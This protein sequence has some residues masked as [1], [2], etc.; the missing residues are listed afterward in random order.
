MDARRRRQLEWYLRSALAIA[1][2]SN[3]SIYTHGPDNIG[4][5]GL[6]TPTLTWIT[7]SSVSKPQ[8]AITFAPTSAA[9]VSDILAIT[10]NGVEYNKTLTA[11]HIAEGDY[12]VAIPELLNAT[13]TVWLKWTRGANYVYSNTISITI[14]DPY[15]VPA[16]TAG[17]TISGTTAPTGDLTA[18]WT[19]T[20]RP[21]PTIAHQWKRGGSNVGTNSATYTKSGADVGFAM[22]DDITASSLAGSTTLSSNAINVVAAGTFTKTYGNRQAIGAVTSVTWASADFGT[23]SGSTDVIIAVAYGFNSISGTP[24]LTVDG[25]S[26]TVVLHNDT[27]VTKTIFYRINLTSGGTKTVVISTA[28][29]FFQ[30]NAY[31][32]IGKLGA[33]LN[34]VASATYSNGYSANGD[35]H[36]FFSGQ[37]VPASGVGVFVYFIFNTNAISWSG[38]T[39]IFD[40]FNDGTTQV[41]W[42]WTDSDTDPTAT[43]GGNSGDTRTMVAWGP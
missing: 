20:G 7:P 12:S 1:T 16:F 17:P 4:A 25:V 24:T 5:S 18:T 40:T 13:Y 11:Q 15:T 3:S 31:L 23:I 38:T 21:T 42:G 10:I 32:M 41:I 35:P 9:A 43:G 28:A 22:T 2:S 37:S 27:T 6:L 33:G 8:F 26:A 34:P 14:N 30:Y 29:G 36:V 39:A 19:V